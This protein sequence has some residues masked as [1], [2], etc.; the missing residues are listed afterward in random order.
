[1]TGFL[2][3]L[4]RDL[5]LAWRRPG[6][7]AVVLAFFVVATVLFPLGIGPQ[8]SILAR[9]AAGVLWCT[10]LFA[11][12]LSL[13]RLFAV[14]YE[15]GSLD[16]LLLAPWPLEL[17]A[18]AKCAA[19]WIV[20]GVPLAVLAPLLGVAFGLPPGALI[21]LAATL[22]VGTP[23]LSLIG[24]LAAALTL[25]ARRGGALLALLALPLCV[26]TLIFGVSAIEALMTGEDL[27][28]HI[29]ILGALALVALATIPWAMAAALR[30]AGE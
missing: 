5:R 27:W 21:A 20:T 7:V 4:S 22:L 17:G 10:A 14:D 23:T 16:L 25:G 19:H 3:L 9:I 28:A 24:G 30:Q 12:M 29:A 15:D 6:D 1:M 26:P 11:S 18:L 2:A 13:D 8:A